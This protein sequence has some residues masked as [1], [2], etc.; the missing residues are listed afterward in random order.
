[1]MKGLDSSL[2]QKVVHDPFI[3][4]EIETY[5][6]TN[7]A[8][9]EIWTT[10]SLLPETTLC[11]NECL[12]INWHDSINLSVLQKSFIELVIKHPAL[13]ST[14]TPDGLTQMFHKISAQNEKNFQLEVIH[15]KN[16]Y[17]TLL[18]LEQQAKKLVLQPFTLTSGAPVSLTA[19]SENGKC[20]HS[21][22]TFHHII[23]DGESA[24]LLVKDLIQIYDSLLANSFTR[25]TPMQPLPL[26]KASAESINYWKN[27]LAA[28][29]T[30]KTFKHL[31]HKDRGLFRSFN[32]SRFD[33]T[34]N[35]MISR[36]LINSARKN[37]VSLF[38]FLL[39]AFNITLAK[40]NNTTD[41]TLGLCT[42][43]HTTDSNSV[44]HRVIVRPLK[45][46]LVNTSKFYDNLK[47][48]DSQLMKLLDSPFI[49]YGEL[50]SL[51]KNRSV[52]TGTSPLFSIV[53]NFDQSTNVFKYVNSVKTYPRVYENFEIF[54]NTFLTKEN[55]ISFEVQ[56]NKDI[57]TAKDINTLFNQFQTDLETSIH[58]NE[59]FNIN[60]TVPTVIHAATTT[61]APVDGRHLDAILEIWRRRL[62]VSH[63]TSSSNF[64]NSG[65]HSILALEIAKEI[66]E[67]FSVPFT[68]KDV[69][70]NPTPAGQSTILAQLVDT[71][72]PAV[73]K[74]TEPASVV[75]I[76]LITDDLTIA[77]QQVMFL[78][79]SQN[80][81]AL[82]N[83][84][85]A[86]LVQDP[87]NKDKLRTALHQIISNNDALRTYFKS[88]NGR[89]ARKIVSP[90][91]FLDFKIEEIT[92][93]KQ[94][95][96]ALLKESA[97]EPFDLSLWPLMKVKICRTTCG[98]NILFFN[99]HH[100]IWDGWSFDLFFEELNRNY[101]GSNL[102]SISELNNLYSTFALTE[103]DYL[104]SQQG[105]ADREYWKNVYS[106]S[107]TRLQLPTLTNIHENAGNTA[108]AFELN[109]T[110]DLK[111]KLLAY[112]KQSS[113]S[114][115]CILLAGFKITLAKYSQNSDIVVGVPV[116]NRMNDA[117][118]KTLGYFVNTL[119]VR[120]QI[121]LDSSFQEIL[122]NVQSNFLEALDHQ[123]LPFFEIKRL[124]PDESRSDFM[125]ALFSF[126]EV[127]Q[128][129]SLFN[130]KPYSQVNFNN[131]SSHTPLDLWI[132]FSHQKIEG[133]LQYK[134]Q[135]Y[136]RSF[137]ENFVNLY[138]HTLEAAV[139]NFNKT[140]K[141]LSIS[142]SQKNLLAKWGT[143]EQIDNNLSLLD[144]FQKSL[145][146][147]PTKTAVSCAN[148][149]LT[150]TELDQISDRIASRI[151]LPQTST[152][153]KVG[154]CLERTAQL[155]AVLLAILKC[156]YTYIPLDHAFPP[157]R[158]HY[159][160]ADSQLDILITEKNIS[161]KPTREETKVLLLSQ[162]IDK[163]NMGFKAEP[164]SKPQSEDTAYILY[165]SGTTGTPKGVSV[166][167]N[168]LANFILA[169]QGMAIMNAND[170]ILAHTTICFDISFL[171]ILLPILTGASAHLVNKTDILEAAGLNQIIAKHGINF[172]QA[173]PSA[174]K[175]LMAQN[176]EPAPHSFKILSG[177]ERLPQEVA[178]YLLTCTSEVYNM[179][180]PTETTIWSSYQ[181]LEKEV[182]ITAGRPI[183]NT[184][185]IILNENGEVLP[186]HASGELYIGGLGLSGGYYHKSDLTEKKFKLVTNQLMS[187]VFFAT[188][189]LAQWNKSGEIEIL[190]RNDRQ[191][192]INGF[193][194]ELF[195][196]E[197]HLRKLQIFKD[198]HVFTMTD[199]DYQKIVAALC[200]ESGKSMTAEK[201]RSELSS[202][203]PHYMVPQ[204]IIFLNEIPR[205]QSQKIDESALSF[206]V[207]KGT[208]VTAPPAPRVNMNEKI[209]D[210]WRTHLKIASVDDQ[211]TFFELG[212]HS[213]I[214]LNLNTHLEEVLKVK[215]PLRFLIESKHFKDFCNKVNNLN[216]NSFADSKSLVVLKAGLNKRNSLFCFH[217]VGGSALNY[218]IFSSYINPD[219]Y[220][221][222]FQ[223]IALNGVTPMKN[224]I[225][226]M[227]AEYVEELLEFQPEGPYTLCGGSMGGIL[228]YE[229]AQQLKAKGHKIDKLILF[230]TFGPD[231]DLLNFSAPL[232][233]AKDII[234]KLIKPKR[235]E[236]KPKQLIDQITEKNYAL[237][238]KYK[239]KVYQG[240]ILLIRAN[241][242]LFGSY[243]EPHMGWKSAI[244][245]KIH[246]LEINA[247]HEAFIEDATFKEAFLTFYKS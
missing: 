162:L 189:D 59:M 167:Y 61:V 168:S 115:Y 141:S 214:A 155:P 60:N 2:N 191:V 142:N 122:D 34:L 30:T 120:S 19:V 194:L 129:K 110:D 174:W 67:K 89:L 73:S 247:P 177:G 202:Y 88:E 220:L 223:T 106:N 107:L 24:Y 170:K 17:E 207:N 105:I 200:L 231:V 112:T 56:Y 11:Y 7:P 201:I 210:I 46:A 128:R 29:A 14:L 54:V 176:W 152:K 69:F 114:L 164:S 76:K 221:I 4:G 71:R 28:L 39:T 68:I 150:Y 233:K 80:I 58:N 182:A 238:F 237:L 45:S 109:F 187:G 99:F 13:R 21:I 62:R 206:L 6:S 230:D 227:C 180:G 9:Q 26:P 92:S 156:G 119:P 52:E 64:F 116:Q 185:F 226:E 219:Q 111:D 241:R 160:V 16:S 103:Q 100:I 172:I 8:Q 37:H 192:K 203:L 72:A 184:Q 121:N 94:E 216:E 148:D 22:L 179:Y 139:D 190:G 158:L 81:G 27:E 245:G 178:D 132:K 196:I 143:G 117:Y 36:G 147:Y 77:Q 163:S 32:S 102:S 197:S 79:R 215:I 161:Y 87:I 145:D 213:L 149:S 175:M 78:E 51:I 136:S 126:Q 198:V 229:V 140:V 75:D 130:N 65:G 98:E 33:L 53:F 108:S 166:S 193:R 23:C 133:G 224:S 137:I 18:A 66:V 42:S 159:I 91:S 234:R 209:R 217:A 96:L 113:S 144:Y 57:F 242:T 228:A 195:E 188:G 15:T 124:V 243:S 173:T 218:S 135:L 47:M 232:D 154:V 3:D 35:S 93:T 84:P 146:L 222:G 123:Q 205:T 43:S 138:M 118:K 90:Q 74:Q 204:D 240:D 244:D 153:I 1:M 127:S 10:L 208:T 186:P 101:S 63:L 86:L 20:D 31:A 40:A 239:A 151:K 12:V 212:G 82:H 199:G 83:L 235:V 55:E 181:K 5:Q 38:S 131:N 211:N 41:V 169:M 104:N 44:G 134:D 25:S 49:G 95:I 183:Y 171:E 50:V 70:V 165:T 125:P 97:K 48:I 85:A 225:E 246:M 236:I 157:E